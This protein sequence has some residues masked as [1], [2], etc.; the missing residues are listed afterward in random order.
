MEPEYSVPHTKNGILVVDDTPENLHFIVHALKDMG[1]KVR[2]AK[3]GR[4]AIESAKAQPPDLVL[5]DINMPDMNGYEV[6]AAFKS[7]PSLEEIPILFVSALDETFDKVKA[8]DAGGV[9]YITKPFQIEEVAARVRT[10]LVLRRLQL[11]REE[12]IHDL[13]QA[14]SEVRTLQ[15]L[16]PM[17]AYCRKVRDDEGYWSGLEEFVNARAK[18]GLSHGI[19]PACM[20]AH[21]PEVAEQMR[22]KS[23]RNPE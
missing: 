5:L 6:C 7:D 1:F 8:F 9:D 11:E 22:N 16:I 14:L 4:L 23:A 13:E 17:C 15:D 10:H 2:P 21:H 3:S 19:C 20:H 12:I 18:D